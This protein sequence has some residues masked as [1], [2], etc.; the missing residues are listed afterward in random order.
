MKKT[1]HFKTKYLLLLLI[2]FVFLTIFLL[3]F[4]FSLKNREKSAVP[5]SISPQKANA[6][7]EDYQKL[8]NYAENK[9]DIN[10]SEEDKDNCRQIKTNPLTGIILKVEIDK[11][12]EIYDFTYTGKVI[13]LEQTNQNN[14]DY[15]QLTLE[16]PN[17][18][19]YVLL[20]TPDL[21]YDDSSLGHI[22]ADVFRQFIDQ[23]TQF[24]LR[25]KKI[26]QGVW[27]TIQWNSLRFYIN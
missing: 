27:Q 18:S 3:I 12:Q 10:T 23:E 14:C 13:K 9:E 22:S 21:S 26:S 2:F 20:F 25:L 15:Y 24:G 7:H 19:Q 8:E 4:Y 6:L 5:S 11:E 1:A 17:G 16:N